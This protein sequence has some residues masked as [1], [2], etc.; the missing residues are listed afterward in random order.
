MKEAENKNRN[1]RKDE[2][3]SRFKISA[4]GEEKDI[5]LSKG[6]SFRLKN[7]G[8]SEKASAGNGP[9][10]RFCNLDY[11]SS[12][13]QLL[14]FPLVLRASTKSSTTY[15]FF[16]NTNPLATHGFFFIMTD[17][18][19]EEEEEEENVGLIDG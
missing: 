19:T 10:P 5:I 6:D 9:P 18:T 17:S 11:P 8:P 4:N 14:Y 13:I 15:I 2:K 7:P 12:Y 3:S 1:G 16:R